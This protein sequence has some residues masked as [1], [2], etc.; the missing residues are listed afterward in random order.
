MA[1]TIVDS[2]NNS[3][4]G[5]SLTLT[6]LTGI[7]QNDIIIICADCE[8]ASVSATVTGFT[9][10]TGI[11]NTGQ[12][13]FFTNVL[14]KIAGASES[15]SYTITGGSGTTF[16]Q[17]EAIV[18]R[19]NAITSP[20]DKS[21]T[22]I[23]NGGT[24]LSVTSVTTTQIDL[25][26]FF[27]QEFQS[28]S[29]TDPTGY[30]NIINNTVNSE[31]ASYKI[32]TSAGAT[33]TVT[34]TFNSAT[35]ATGILIA[36]LPASSGSTKSSG[37]VSVSGDVGGLLISAGAI[38]PSKIFSTGSDVGGLIIKA[39]AIRPIKAS[40]IGSDSGGLIVTYQ[41]FIPISAAI[42]S[43]KGGLIIFAG[44]IRKI[45]PEPIGGDS[46]GLIGTATVSGPKIATAIIGS[47]IGGLN[48]RA[49]A[50]IVVSA[51]IGDDRGGLITTA[52]IIKTA[53]AAIGSTP[54]SGLRVFGE[55]SGGKY[56]YVGPKNEPYL[57]A[58]D[59]M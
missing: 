44:A 27:A 19:G 31:F 47:D 50:I 3:G 26:L 32:Q 13:G 17:G 7:L 42:G 55:L 23:L 29:Y 5:S 51:Q 24:S 52:G 15:G 10:I 48:P 53:S 21:N 25:L 14:Y 58:G 38:R 2:S 11:H 20:I 57:F 18:I 9:N 33:G 56:I 49:S 37:V 43:D 45:T 54:N 41:V 6:T 36:I 28:N 39:G 34:A 4:A 22:G 16:V 12:G 40:G 59:I 46:G 30:T 1:W 35:D 8:T